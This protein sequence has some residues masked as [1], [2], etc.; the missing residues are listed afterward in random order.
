MNRNKTSRYLAIKMDKL[1]ALIYLNSF[2]NCPKMD[3][4]DLTVLKKIVQI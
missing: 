2:I 1:I 3:F 4:T